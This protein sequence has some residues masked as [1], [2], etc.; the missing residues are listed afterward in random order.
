[1]VLEINFFGAGNQFFGA[2]NHFFDENLV[3]EIH[4][5]GFG[6]FDETS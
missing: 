4:C 1:M 3:L 5:L 2:G 6:N